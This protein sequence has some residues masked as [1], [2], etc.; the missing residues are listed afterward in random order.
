MMQVSVLEP[1]AR[2]AVAGEVDVSTVADLR[3][4]L[5]AAADHGPSGVD[6]VLD[7][8]GLAF[9]DATGLGVLLSTHR[10]AHRA[11]RRLVLTG[12]SP[13]LGRL[14]FVSRLARVLV[15]DDTSAAA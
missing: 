14:L 10:R 8:G 3:T 6:L 15:V 4:A 2:L 1:G 5:H 7:C 9:V 11:G 13:A 12:V